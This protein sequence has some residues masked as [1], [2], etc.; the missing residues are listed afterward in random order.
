MSTTIAGTTITAQTRKDN[1]D[2]LTLTGKINGTVRVSLTGD[3][4][5]LH[6][7]TYRACDDPRI[8]IDGKTRDGIKINRAEYRGTTEMRTW[9]WV[10]NGRPLGITWE[11]THRQ[12]QIGV[13]NVTRI[14]PG[15]WKPRSWSDEHLTD[16]AAKVLYSFLVELATL[17]D[18]PYRRAVHALA[19]QDAKMMEARRT[20]DE[21]DQA[22]TIATADRNAARRAW[23]DAPCQ[24]FPGESPWNS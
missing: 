7:D 1:I 18:T 16:A 14:F 4:V 22:L 12:M 23:L 6:L 17:V 10:E 13:N 19:V 5:R 8:D 24:P 9:A 11:N 20:R 2:T 21:A 3:G 15:E